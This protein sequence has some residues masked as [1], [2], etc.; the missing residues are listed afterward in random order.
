MTNISRTPLY[1][2]VLFTGLK[3]LALGIA[4]ARLTEQIIRIRK[5]NRG[6]LIMHEAKAEELKVAAVIKHGSREYEDRK[7]MMT[8][9]TTC[10]MRTWELIAGCG[11][12]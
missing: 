1:L 2:L 12:Q 9:F 5:L 4:E 3:K 11:A 6:V 7:R 10:L 8:R